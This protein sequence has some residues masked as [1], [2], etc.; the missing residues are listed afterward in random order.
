M[1]LEWLNVFNIILL[2]IYFIYRKML[3]GYAAHGEL[4]SENGRLLLRHWEA[5]FWFGYA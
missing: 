3:E 5:I 4:F 1:L 2:L